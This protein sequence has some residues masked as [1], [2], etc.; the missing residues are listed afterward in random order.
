V[1]INL[2]INNNSVRNGFINVDPFAVPG[3]GKVGGDVGNLDHVACDA[4][5]DEIVADDILDYIPND[6]SGD[7]L[8]NWIGKLR[9]GGTLTIG[10]VDLREVSRMFTRQEIDVS[11]AN[12]VLYGRQRLPLEYRKSTS[13]I[14]HVIN[15]LESKG[16]KILNKRIEGAYYSVTARRP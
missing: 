4:E 14:Q 6:V 15:M 8:L 5:C 3:D 2:L 1:K 16:L 7:T 9:H 10:G 13:T 12:A 11:E